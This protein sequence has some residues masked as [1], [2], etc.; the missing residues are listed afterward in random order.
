GGM[1]MGGD[2]SGPGV[3]GGDFDPGIG[4]GTYTIVY[5]Y[6]DGNGCSNSASQDIMV[7][8]PFFD[9]ALIVVDANTDIE[10]FA[11]TDGMVI[12]KTSIGNTPLGI[13][14]NADLNP[15]NVFF[16]LTGPI[17]EQRGEGPS[18][19]YS[20]FGDIGVDIQGEPFPVGMYT[21]IANPSVGPTQNISFE[22]S[23]VDPLC[24]NYE[25]GIEAAVEISSCG[26]D[27]GAIYIYIAGGISPYTYDWSHDNSLNTG[28]ALN[29]EAGTYSVTVTDGNGCM[30]SISYTLSDPDLP[31]V[32]LTPFGDVLI[33]DPSFTLTGGSPAG[34]TYSGPG[35]SG[36]DFSPAAAGAGTHTIV[37]SYE[38]PT[39]GCE[40]SASQDITVIDPGAIDRVVEFQ[41]VD[42]I[43][44]DDLFELED[45]DVLPGAVAIN[46]RAITDP[47]VVGSVKFN[48][49]GEQSR[50]WTEN[51]APYA[52]FG[53]MSGNFSEND[54]AP[55][56]YTLTATPY[57]AA[58]GNG[59][60]GQ[61]LTVNF[62]VTESSNNFKQTVNPVSVSPN[63]ADR[64][65]QLD[66]LE[67]TWI[68]D[69]YLFDVSG[70][71]VKT[72]KADS[73]GDVDSYLMRVQDLPEATYFVKIKRNRGLDLQQRVVIKR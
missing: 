49:S 67:P 45:G 25:V 14:Y 59:M 19:P 60:A 21:L 47:A 7:N 34:G 28:A 11:L 1:P 65:A 20:L 73:G 57:S 50:N 27:D 24:Q 66:F 37:Y 16:K 54:L 35:V 33:S 55:G 41:L 12:P 44:D 23:D 13:I 46:I 8:P 58:G 53:D 70:K 9:A 43:T 71:L 64:T 15:G 17:N 4:P 5:E 69:I 68:T 31:V 40:N 26:A 62:E 22:V 39:T 6:T 52:L 3:S 51:F 63:P 72:I 56:N 38:D 30:D 29:L 61:A 36:G 42:A 10:L 48:L 32:T 18:P 2:Y